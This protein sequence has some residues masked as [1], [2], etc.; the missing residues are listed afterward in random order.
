MV[1]HPAISDVSTTSL[2]FW[3]DITSDKRQ[4]DTLHHNIQCNLGRSEDIILCVSLVARTCND[5]HNDFFPNLPEHLTSFQASCRYTNTHTQHDFKRYV[6]TLI[7]TRA[8]FD[9]HCAVAV[10]P[11]RVVHPLSLLGVVDA[12][13][14]TEI[15]TRSVVV[16]V[17]TRLQIY[18]QSNSMCINYFT[19]YLYLTCS[20]FMLFYACMSKLWNFHY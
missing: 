2:T 1:S 3:N 12:Q 14:R 11:V 20:S 10:F 17:L 9:T 19:L 8:V 6:D 15:M 16:E 18:N 7:L 13:S 4:E 5:C